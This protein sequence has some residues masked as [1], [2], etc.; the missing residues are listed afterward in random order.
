MPLRS[1]LMTNWKRGHSNIYIAWGKQWISYLSKASHYQMAVLLLRRI[2]VQEIVG[3]KAIVPTPIF[4]RKWHQLSRLMYDLFH[5]PILYSAFI[6]SRHFYQNTSQKGTHGSSPCRP[7]STPPI[8]DIWEIKVLPQYWQS[9]NNMGSVWAWDVNLP[10]HI[11]LQIEV[12]RDNVDNALQSLDSL[13]LG[14]AFQK[15]PLCYI[16]NI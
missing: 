3:Y 9:Y 13:S 5:V 10:N 14:N 6:D 4:D 2:L 12:W 15:M 1:G 7:L 11:L 16:A 8:C